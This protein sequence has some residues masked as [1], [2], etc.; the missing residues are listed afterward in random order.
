[1]KSVLKVVHVH[2]IKVSEEGKSLAIPLA[3]DKH[4]PFVYLVF[5]WRKLPGESCTG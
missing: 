4:Q 2:C 3:R 5:L 1:M